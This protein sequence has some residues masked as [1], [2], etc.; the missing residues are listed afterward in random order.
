MGVYLDDDRWR[1]I[2]ESVT[3]TFVEVV[4]RVGPDRWDGPG[5]GE[6][7]LRDLVGHASRALLTVE[8]YLAREAG[9]ITLDGPVA[10]LAAAATATATATGKGSQAITDRG[11]DA[12]TALGADPAAAVRTIADRVVALVDRTA[13]DAPCATPFGGMTLA[14]Y[15]PT[16]AFE[17]TVHTLDIA[18]S[19]GEVPPEKLHEPV[20]ACLDLAAEAIG[21]TPLSGEVL[22]ALTG[23]KPLPRELHVI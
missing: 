15:L 13:D 9:T 10:Y 20:A 12:G 16:R 5:L 14:S 8:L 17:L 7:T 4:G 19:L 22:L 1:S 6:W 11:R 2:F 18:H 3:E 23:R 21:E